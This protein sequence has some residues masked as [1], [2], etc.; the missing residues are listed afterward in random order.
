MPVGKDPV[1]T[2]AT[3]GAGGKT[4]CGPE[5]HAAPDPQIRNSRKCHHCHFRGHIVK[6]CTQ[7]I[8]PCGKIGHLSSAC[9]TNQKPPIKRGPKTKAQ[10]VDGA[11]LEAHSQRMGELDA[12]IEQ[13]REQNEIAL[14]NKL[15]KTEE[16]AERF[17][18]KLLDIA[19]ARTAVAKISPAVIEFKSN[20]EFVEWSCVTKLGEQMLLRK[21]T[22]YRSVMVF[23]QYL[24][25]ILAT[26]IFMDLMGLSWVVESL[27]ST[28]LSDR[29]L[30]KWVFGVPI[31]HTL[32][33]F[34]PFVRGY[35]GLLH[36]LAW[37]I[38]GMFPEVIQIM[39][40]ALF[41]SILLVLSLYPYTYLTRYIAKL[42]LLRRNY[43][44]GDDHALIHFM[45]QPRFG[46][47]RFMGGKYNRPFSLHVPSDR[48][49]GFYYPKTK[50]DKKTGLK[51]PVMVG[52]LLT[53]RPL[54]KWKR[55]SFYGLT[56]DTI[57][58]LDQRP[59]SMSL[60]KLVFVDP[61]SSQ[62]RLTEW[63]Q[64]PDDPIVIKQLYDTGIRTVSSELL[65][66]LADPMVLNP[67]ESP[68]TVKFRL[69]RKIQNTHSVNNSKYDI[70]SGDNVWI[71]TAAVVFFFYE[72]VVSDVHNQSQLFLKDQM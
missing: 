30:F 51:I 6:D 55:L 65:M 41:I 11:L 28:L 64:V 19:A 18:Q 4:D 23:L 72:K 46:R 67:L 36:F 61:I 33:F 3:F 68:E 62:Y 22:M 44:K 57:S 10:L 17:Q 9:K 37:M 59:L 53:K 60:S 38:F 29:L 71:N 42:D 24:F 20:T 5:S 34:R 13:I 52:D 7:P 39:G 47:I 43:L 26:L 50:K 2:A 16:E 35:A 14:D 45:A 32:H 66:Q 15:T 70:L 49:Y 54:P 27:C 25:I 8:C 69:N 58:L 63:I 12:K 21:F 1:S 40:S 48:S 56:D 31:R